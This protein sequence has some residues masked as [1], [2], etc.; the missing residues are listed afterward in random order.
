LLSAVKLLSASEPR[1]LN[2]ACVQTTVTAGGAKTCERQG[3]RLVAYLVDL[4]PA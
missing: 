3:F 4:E 2:Y 1:R